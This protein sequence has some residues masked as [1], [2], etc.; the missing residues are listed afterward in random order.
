MTTTRMSHTAASLGTSQMGST[1]GAGSTNNKKKKKKT[2]QSVITST[3]ANHQSRMLASR[4]QAEA[5]GNSR[6]LTETA[7]AEARAQARAEAGGQDAG[8]GFHAPESVQAM[9]LTIQLHARVWHVQFFDATD[10]GE[11]YSSMVP[12]KSLREAYDARVLKT[13]DDPRAVKKNRGFLTTVMVRACL[14]IA[15]CLIY[16]LRLLCC[17]GVVHVE[18]AVTLMIFVPCVRCCRTTWCVSAC[19]SQ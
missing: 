14:G 2:R 1:L 17:C 12:A 7:R 9:A 15:L 18:P 19:K 11:F 13:A 16:F 10:I 8:A 3:T 6:M 4:M 5:V